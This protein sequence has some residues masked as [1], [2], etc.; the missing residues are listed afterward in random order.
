MQVKDVEDVEK[1]CHSKWANTLKK[2][3]YIIETKYGTQK[4]Q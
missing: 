1:D 2:R 4:T 3:T